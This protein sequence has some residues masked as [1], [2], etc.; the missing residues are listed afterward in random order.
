MTPPPPVVERQSDAIADV[1]ARC[2]GSGWRSFRWRTVVR[3][4]TQRRL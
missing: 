4:E 2:A 3:V 1:R